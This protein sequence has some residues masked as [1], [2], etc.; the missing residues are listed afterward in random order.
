MLLGQCQAKKWKAGPGGPQSLCRDS[1][2]KARSEAAR[3]PSENP[4]E[5]GIHLSRLE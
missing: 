2:C 3:A 1:G 4:G 5:V